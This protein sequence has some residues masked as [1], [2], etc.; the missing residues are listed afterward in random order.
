[1]MGNDAELTTTDP[2]P[3]TVAETR[4]RLLLTHAGIKEQLE[5]VRIDLAAAGPD[6]VGDLLA[7]EDVMVAAAGAIQEEYRALVPVVEVSRNPFTDELVTQSID[8]Y[9]IDG[10]WWDL[11]SPVRPLT[12]PGSDLI[13]VTGAL[14]LSDQLEWTSFLVR[15]GPAVPFVIPEILSGDGVSAVLSEHPVG[16]HLG[17]LIMYF[18]VD[19]PPYAPRAND[20]ASNTATLVESD[21]SSRWSE[22]FHVESDYDFD[23]RPW[24]EDGSLFWIDGGDDDLVLR[25]GAKECPYLDLPGT[26]AIQ[27]VKGGEVWDST[28]VI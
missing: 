22:E 20:W 2:A 27:R 15:P 11:D 24:L 19:Y 18:S 1:M 12:A 13:A 25:R 16:D 23:L 4:Q 26:R 6:S 10:W 5:Q 9:G 8:F 14:N 7:A 3:E 28:D 21:G 17:Y